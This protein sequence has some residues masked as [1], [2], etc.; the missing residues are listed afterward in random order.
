MSAIKKAKRKQSSTTSL[1]VSP[2]QWVARLYQKIAVKFLF[3]N[4]FS[5]LFLDPG[6]GKTSITLRTI[7]M[8]LAA[9][10]IKGVLIIAPLRVCTSVWPRE[11]KKWSNFNHLKIVVL[12]GRDRQAVRKGKHDIYVI[13]PENL[14]WLFRQ[15]L[16]IA[17]D[18][19]DMPF[20]ALWV[21]E[22]TRF[23]NPKVE[24][25]KKKV[26]TKDGDRLT[27]FGY[28]V[29]FLP[30]FKRRHIMTGTP[31]P[32][33][34]M[35]L[36]SQMY[37]VDEGECLGD[38]FYR[39]RNRHFI[40]L[41]ENGYSWGIKEGAADKIHRAIAPRVLEMK[42]SDWLD[43][44]RLLYNSIYVDLPEDA[45][46]L[47]RRMERDMWIECDE[48]VASADAAAQASMK[49]HQ[50]ANGRIYEDIDDPTDPAQRKARKVLKV[51]TAKLE[52]LQG[53][54][55]ELNGK[56]VLVAYQFKHDLDALRDLLGHDLPY[57]GSGVGPRQQKRLEDAWN[58]GLL[59]VLAG[60]P[61]SMGHGLNLQE[62]ANDVCW[63]SLTWNLENYIQFID[64]VFRSGVKGDQ[65]RVHHLIARGT[66]DEAMMW[67]LGE[68]AD[69]QLEAREAISRY[70]SLLG[71][72]RA[73]G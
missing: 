61:D 21:D 17:K 56:P 23:R 63:F 68:R 2:E 4:P 20:D 26:K 36:W 16:A 40:K 8:L 13:N 43:M 18:K 27:R 32:K 47:Y 35:D 57:I 33:S 41:D 46:N 34:L 70:R 64:R 54:I 9:R 44:P 65:V 69:Q 60:H 73:A 11:V 7:S 71:K 42:A 58:A 67:R 48:G 49:C 38:N 14:G 72:N 39:F 66:V 1:R 22:S 59:P 50:I 53:L 3:C 29:Q 31:V 12:R 19:G 24:N 30:I 62:S 28:L 6:L 10:E 15:L 5:A 37:I 25:K 55:E 45:L 52:A 51:H